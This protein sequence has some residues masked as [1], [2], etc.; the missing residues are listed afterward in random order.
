MARLTQWLMALAGLLTSASMSSCSGGNGNEEP[1]PP[2]DTEQSVEKPVQD[3]AVDNLPPADDASNDEPSFFSQYPCEEWYNFNSCDDRLSIPPKW[4]E[5]HDYFDEKNNRFW[6]TYPFI[7]VTDHPWL[8][9]H[10]KDAAYD[11]F[12]NQYI[13]SRA[14]LREVIT[15]CSEDQN[16]ECDQI[17]HHSGTGLY[18][19]DRYL[20]KS[21]KPD[22][23]KDPSLKIIAMP[24]DVSGSL[25]KRPV[26]KVVRS[27]FGELAACYEKEFKRNKNVG[28]GSVTVSCLIDKTGAVSSITIATP[29]F[30]IKTTLNNKRVEDCLV[31]TISRWRFPE[32]RG[33]VSARVKYQ[34]D[35]ELQT[36]D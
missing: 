10:Y 23:K 12:H 2:V 15:N 22:I 35:F 5:L 18:S 19:Q 29:M 11:P 25:D 26:Q 36:D 9:T 16:T 28:N 13:P 27:H 14:Y 30:Q 21:L 34:F 17:H 32:P 24:P 20:Y 4:Y 31:E 7:T 1:R 6:R 3:G 33:G 8:T